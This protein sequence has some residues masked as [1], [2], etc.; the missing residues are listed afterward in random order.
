MKPFPR[1]YLELTDRCN[2]ACPFCAGSNGTREIP[3]ERLEPVLRQIAEITSEVRPHVLG[4]PLIY[5]HLARFLDLCG[6][7]SLTVKIT[8]NGL[9]V[10]SVR[11]TL[12]GAS[13]LREL[14]FSLHSYDRSTHGSP[15]EYLAP[16]FSLCDEFDMRNIPLHVN[17]RFWNIGAESSPDAQALFRL[18]LDHYKCDECDASMPEEGRE[19]VKL[20][21]RRRVHFDERFEW[22]SPA[23][24]VIHDNGFCLGG[25][26][27]IGVLSDG[28]VVPCCLDAGGNIPL[29]NIFTTPLADI[30]RSPRFAAM[31]DGFSRHILTE[32]LCKR[33]SYISRFDR[34]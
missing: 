34:Q 23:R 33:C 17:F 19:S 7:L 1:V 16:V 29:G 12:L 15:E 5:P 22:P 32:D 2:L 31:R 8:T 24:P 30:I 13:A 14:N 28:T 6:E 11:D 27:H 20:V 25:I 10:D 21:N 26:S 3:A 9:A 18:L 4:E